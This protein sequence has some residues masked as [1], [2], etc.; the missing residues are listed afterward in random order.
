MGALIYNNRPGQFGGTL[1]T[2][3]RIPAVSLSL[4]S[5]EAILDLMASGAVE[6]TVS[7]ATETRDSQNVIA[8]KPGDGDDAGVILLEG[9]YDTVPDVPGANDNGSGIST[10]ITI[11]RAVSERSYPLTLRFIAFGSE[12]LGLFGSSFYVESLG[13]EERDRVLVMINLDALA[14]GDGLGVLG[15]SELVS[16]VVAYGS[17]N[18]LPVEQRFALGQGFSSDPASFQRVEIPVVYFLDD[19]IARIHTSEDST[20]FV[21]P[22]LMGSA[23]ALSMALIELLAEP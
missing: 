4:E 14:G 13:P 5:G 10:L 23:A 16:R 7:V 12:E 3:G 21:K 22:K 1:R 18:G 11:A 15:D 6:A 2:Q 9:H 20:E 8:E 17:E 19:E